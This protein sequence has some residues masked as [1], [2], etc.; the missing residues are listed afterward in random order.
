MPFLIGKQIYKSRRRREKSDFAAMV[1]G[2]G[3]VQQGLLESARF[4]KNVCNALRPASRGRR[5]Y[6]LS[7]CRRPQSS[8]NLAEG[9]LLFV[10]LSG[11]GGVQQDI[12]KRDFKIIYIYIHLTIYI[13]LYKHIYIYIYISFSLS[14]SLCI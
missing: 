2:R 4:A 9:T 6:R 8:K 10:H 11:N 14:L 3:G 5:I 1:G 7:S 12:N 13:Y